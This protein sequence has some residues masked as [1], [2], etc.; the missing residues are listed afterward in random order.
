MPPYL[1]PS[2]RFMI[3]NY[4]AVLAEN[5]LGNGVHPR[6]LNT[7]G[8][9]PPASSSY[10]DSA[11]TQLPQA[12]A[13][14]CGLCIIEAPGGIRL[15]YWVCICSE[16]LPIPNHSSSRRMYFESKI[17]SILLCVFW[18]LGALV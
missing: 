10:L 17:V 5:L 2:Y 15:V 7:S 13:D 12:P 1:I 11:S 9:L 6:S 3:T 8:L 14:Y 4:V 16:K 18:L